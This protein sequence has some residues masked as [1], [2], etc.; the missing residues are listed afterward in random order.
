M[1]SSSAKRYLRTSRAVD[2][3]TVYAEARFYKDE[4]PAGLEPAY[5]AAEV[6]ENL[7]G[8]INLQPAIG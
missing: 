5:N 4:A 3:Y 7:K 6:L 2:R 8:R 1:V